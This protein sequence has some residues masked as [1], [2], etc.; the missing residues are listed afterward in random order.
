[1]SEKQAGA[2]HKP[3]SVLPGGS[4]GYLSSSPIAQ[5]V[6]QPT[7]PQRWTI[8]KRGPFWPCFGWGLPSAQCHH[9]AGELLPRHF[10]LAPQKG[11][12]QSCRAVCFL[13]HFP[14]IARS[15]C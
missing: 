6:K 2:G 9:Q 12:I 3:N 14:P 5:G 10:T 15:R 13:W 8:L 1:M 7:R 4:G 11:Y